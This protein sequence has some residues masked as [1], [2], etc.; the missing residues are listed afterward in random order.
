M[1][2]CGSDDIFL[3][4]VNN[5]R[6]LRCGGLIRFSGFKAPTRVDLYRVQLP[7]KM[8]RNAAFGLERILRRNVRDHA[9]EGCAGATA[10]IT[11][12]G[13]IT[14]YTIEH[15]GSRQVDAGR[16]PDGLRRWV[17]KVRFYEYSNQ[18]AMAYVDGDKVDQARDLCPDEAEDEDGYN[19]EDGCPDEDNDADGIVDAQDRCPDTAEDIDGINDGGGCPEKEDIAFVQNRIVI[20][21]ERMFSESDDFTIS[22]AGLFLVEGLANWWRENG[23]GDICVLAH[24]NRNGDPEAEQAETIRW[25]DSVARAFIDRGIPAGQVRAEGLGSGKPIVA[26][27]APEAERLNVRIEIEQCVL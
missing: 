4:G 27:A 15:G 26:P 24:T 14:A 19:D 11:P 7:D 22:E 25:A 1:R 2:E 10:H 6:R 16:Y 18:V 23:K 13:Q 12:D 21:H 20:S 17:G 3:L 9:G 5:D 8:G